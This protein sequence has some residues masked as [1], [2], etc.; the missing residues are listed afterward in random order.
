[1]KIYNQYFEF[2]CESHNAINWSVSN[3]NSGPYADLNITWWGR[4]VCL[5]THSQSKSLISYIN[6]LYLLADVIESY[7]TI[8]AGQAEGKREWLNHDNTRD[9]MLATAS[10]HVDPET[11]YDTF[12]IS[13][14]TR[15]IFICDGRVFLSKLLNEINALTKAVEFIH[16]KSCTKT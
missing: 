4:T 2:C 9:F 14:C 1:M 8:P 12:T 6:K 10:Y 7:L 15:R 16:T 3:Y 11:N 13:D 5:H